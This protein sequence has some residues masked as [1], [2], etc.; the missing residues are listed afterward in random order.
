[1]S[2]PARH[3][4]PKKRFSVKWQGSGYA[5]LDAMGAVVVAPQTNHNLA[6]MACERR[7]READAKA[8]RKV[9]PCIT[10]REAFA[11]DGPHN[12]MC[13]GCRTRSDNPFEAAHG[14]A[15][16]RRRT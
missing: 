15:R 13:A 7:Q 3:Y 16:A 1:M 6:L 2:S 11:S 12:Q 5:V 14:I 10:C 8:N 4:G 9:R